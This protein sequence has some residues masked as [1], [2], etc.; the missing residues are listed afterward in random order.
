MWF[1]SCGAGFSLRRA[2]AR[3]PGRGNR[4]PR[5]LQPAPLVLLVVFSR[6]AFATDTSPDGTTPLHWAAQNGELEAAKKLLKAGANPNAT[7]R[8][9]V[10]PLSLAA[11][12]RDAA[13]ARALLEAG[14][15]ANHSTPGD[16]TILMA[17]ARTGSPEFVELLLKA[18][19]NPNARG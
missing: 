4:V 12:N 3:P 10:T 9:G 11:A 1:S 2:S 16:E 5:W 8:Y 7:N 13:M 18:G 15:D 14:A 19:A 6:A 17:A